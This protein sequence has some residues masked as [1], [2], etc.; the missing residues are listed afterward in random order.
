MGRNKCKLLVVCGPSGSGK[1]TLI[2]RLFK[3]YPDKFGFSVS[4]TTR[5]P[6]PGEIDGLHYYFTTKEQIEEGIRHGKF[7]ETAS[8][9][10]NTYGTSIDSVQK[11][12]DEGKVCILDIETEGV[13]QVKQKD[14]DVILVFIK[15]PSLEVLEERLKARGT[16]TEES[17]KRRLNV[18]KGEI[19]YGE[20]EGNFHTIIINNELEEAY[21]TFKSFIMK[22]VF[23]GDMT[24]CWKTPDFPKH[25]K[26]LFTAI[27]Q[28]YLI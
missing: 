25:K 22:A 27:K 21:N 28:G 20:S 8:F 16:E 3:E 2:Q 14:L 7:L 23:K 10:G 4:H 15:P 26:S 12:C 6:R 1:S 11:V 9:S 5:K 24:E 18:A 17:L 13:K 19:E